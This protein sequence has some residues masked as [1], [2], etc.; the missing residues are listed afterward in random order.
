MVIIPIKNQNI[1]LFKNILPSLFWFYYVHIKIPFSLY[2]IWLRSKA[3]KSAIWWAVILNGLGIV[4]EALLQPKKAAA[5]HTRGI[6]W[7][8]CPS[9]AMNPIVLA[10]VR[11]R[12]NTQPASH[13]AHGL[14]PVI[15]AGP[16]VDVPMLIATKYHTLRTVSH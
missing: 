11:T 6:A 12:D 8:H 3:G 2:I 15:I 4:E 5:R 1:P 14:T 9:C 16:V 10:T 13:G 7:I